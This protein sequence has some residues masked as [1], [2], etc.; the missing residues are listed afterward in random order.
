MRAVRTTTT[1]VLAAGLGLVMAGTAVAAP[2]Q[3]G[4]IEGTT[5]ER[6]ADFCDVEGLVAEVTLTVE[7]RWR[8]VQR[9]RDGLAYYAENVRGTATYAPVENGVAGPVV[10]V[11]VDR[12]LD[13]DLRVTD[14]G[15]GN[16]VV[17]V[18]A[19]GNSVLSDPGG[20]VLAR[21]PGQVRFTLLVPHNGT[22]TDPNDDGDPQFVSLD[23]GSTG[24][25]DD[26]CE[27]LVPLLD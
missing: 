16:L 17:Q 26:F 20:R 25:S 18:L 22:P 12:V 1:G 9:G 6:F 5:T 2:P 4:V 23:K 21:D 27:I 7:G 14:D 24:R 15:Q 8:F 3:R 13:K 11:R 10:A 19:T